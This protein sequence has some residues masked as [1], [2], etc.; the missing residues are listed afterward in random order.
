MVKATHLTDQMPRSHADD[1]LEARY[2][3]DGYVQLTSVDVPS[4]ERTDALVLTEDTWETVCEA[5]RTDA[6][7]TVNDEGD[8]IEIMPTDDAIL[9]RHTDTKLLLTERDREFINETIST[10]KNQLRHDGVI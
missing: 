9:V 5:A 4:D 8:T 2:Y 7:T 1:H 6:S 3:A 10:S